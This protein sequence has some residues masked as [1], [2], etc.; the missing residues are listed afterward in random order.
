MSALQQLHWLPIES[1]IT[2]KLCLIMH[3]VHTNRAPRYLADCVQTIAQSSS[4]PGLRFAN[5][6]TYVKPCTV[7]EPSSETAAF[8]P[9]DLLR[10]TVSQMSYTVSLTLIYL[11]AVSKLYSSREHIVT[12]SVSAPG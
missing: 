6:A 10:G 9:L 3:L 11:N 4:R 2:Y 12:N 5:T 8:A 1:R 7:Q